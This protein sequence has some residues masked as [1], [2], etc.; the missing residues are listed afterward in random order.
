MKSSAIE[1]TA[2]PRVIFLRGGANTGSSIGQTDFRIAYHFPDLGFKTTLVLI[3]RRAARAIE[4]GVEVL[5]V[6]AP[7][8]PLV[9][10]LWANFSALCRLFSRRCEVLVCNPGLSLCG[11]AYKYLRPE[12]KLIL[13][14][15]SVPVE[16]Q[17]V[18]GWVAERLFTLAV[19]SRSLDGLSVITDGIRREIQDRFKGRRDLPTVIW[20]SGVDGDLFDPAISGQG[21]RE[22]Y[23]LHESFVL[24]YHGSLS[25]TRGLELVVQAVARLVAQGNTRLRVLFLGKGTCQARLMALAD[26]LGLGGYVIFLEPVPHEAVPQFVAA[27][28][29]GLDPL[30]DHPWW[31]YSSPLKVY[32]YLH[33]GKPVLASDIPAHRNLSE[34]VLLVPESDPT[35]LAAAIQRLMELDSNERERLRQLALEAGARNTWRMRAE[36]LASFLRNHFLSGDR[37]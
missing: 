32:E 26:E 9:Q 6:A 21:I 27:A 2:V 5:V 17:G 18:P 24:M 36:T 28:D 30:P 25:P 33:M 13:D 20:P 35:A 15:R 31:N 23:G 7:G 29:A 3:G 37:K 16:V 22:Q 10:G 1:E 8:M 4:R 19:R 11:I 14:V 12:T 34:A